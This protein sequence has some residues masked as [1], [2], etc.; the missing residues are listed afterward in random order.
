MR[1]APTR[2]R[3]C[4]AHRGEEGGVVVRGRVEL[5]VGGAARVLGPG[6]AYYFASAMPHRFRNAGASPVRSSRASTPPTLLSTSSAVHPR[7]PTMTRQTGTNA[8]RPSSRARRPSSTAATCPRSRGAT[9]DC[10]NP[11]DGR[12]IARVA[13]TRRGRRRSR[14]RRSARAPSSRAAGRGSRRPRARRC[15]CDSPS[16][17]LANRDELA[18]LETLDMGKPISDSLSVDIPADGATASRWYAEAID[19]IY[20]EVAPTGARCARADHARADGRRRRDRAVEFPAASW[21]RGRSARRSRPAI[22]W[23]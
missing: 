1:P 10:I 9:F 19:K 12:L 2:A 23:C 3:T 21:R 7:K 4:C 20:D 11:V 13:S 17:S 22:R 18:L 6:D 5:T 16:S 8:P 14:G 15:C